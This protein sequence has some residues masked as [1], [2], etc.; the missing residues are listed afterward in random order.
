[1]RQ[2]A[3]ALVAVFAL[4]VAGC[5]NHAPPT[6]TPAGQAAFNQH[7]VQRNL[8]VLRDIAIDAN[9][10]GVISTADTRL[11]VQFHKSAI[12]I[13]H[14]STSG[15]Q[16]LVGTSLDQTLANLSPATRATLNPYVQLIKTAIANLG[17]K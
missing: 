2:L 5:A 16:T 11:V 12:T 13:V 17:G 14:E 3:I 8:D 10:S 4:S 6:L 15:W 7:A 1:M 9:T